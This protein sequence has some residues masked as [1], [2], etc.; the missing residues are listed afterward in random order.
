[1]TLTLSSS[2]R[3]DD[4]PFISFFLFFLHSHSFIL[5]FIT[6]YQLPLASSIS[7]RH[8]STL[9]AVFI[10]ITGFLSPY[11]Y[12]TPDSTI[13]ISDNDIHYPRMSPFFDIIHNVAYFL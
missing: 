9:A 13:D 6:P 2:F 10:R 8:S 3:L 5:D 11:F 1:M 7:S 4:L 12:P